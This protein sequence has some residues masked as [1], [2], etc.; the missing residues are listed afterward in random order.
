LRALEDEDGRP[1]RAQM[2]ALI[3]LG[4]VLV[5]VPLYLWRRPRT[6]PE[7]TAEP[8]SSEIPSAAV[9]AAATQPDAGIVMVRLSDP[10]IVECHD[11][12]SKRTAPEQC[13]HL[14]AFEKAFAHAIEGASS[15]VPSTARPSSFVYVADV[16]YARQKPRAI[17][18]SLPKDGR[19]VKPAKIAT[20]CE[21]SVEHALK[22]VDLDADHSH[23][24]YKIQI[25][26]TYP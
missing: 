21:T 5:A 24:R 16:S 1:A 4:F 25:T 3:V 13:G 17:Q 20:A 2:V 11:P 23:Q 26:A 9:D 10:V 15:C 14:V 12:G 8:A 6:V 19:T 22:A 18:L 7:T